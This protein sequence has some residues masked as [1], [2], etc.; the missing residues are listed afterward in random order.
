M[1]TCSP[2]AVGRGPIMRTI[3]GIAAIAAALVSWQ[4]SAH[5]TTIGAISAEVQPLT[6]ADCGQAGL[7]WDDTGN[8]CD[9]QAEA[10]KEQLASEPT[11]DDWQAEAPKEQLASEPTPDITGAISSG[12]PLTRADCDQAGLTWDD[13]GNVC[14]WQSEG[15][16]EQLA[17][18][19]TAE[20][21]GAITSSQPLT[22]ADCGQA[23]LAWDDNGNVCESLSRRT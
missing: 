6:R 11:P 22:R 8:V 4:P 18:E 14:D 5:A 23:G 20:I 2:M 16:K 12:Q 15:P 1:G 10:P 7:A 17:S 9:W 3:F 13:T 21:T 19:P